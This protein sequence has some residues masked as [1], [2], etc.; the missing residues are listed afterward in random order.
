MPDVRTHS[1]YV[2]DPVEARWQARVRLTIFFS[3]AATTRGVT[4]RCRFGGRGKSGLR[5]ARGPVVKAGAV[6]PDRC[7][8]KVPQ[9]TNR[10]AQAG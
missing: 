7:R 9:K 2:L 1:L 6:L 4:D 5:R 3:F 8:R 10:P